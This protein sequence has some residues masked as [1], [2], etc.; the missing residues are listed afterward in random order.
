LAGYFSTFDKTASIVIEREKLIGVEYDYALIV[1][2]VMVIMVL[3]V[4]FPINVIPVKQI[5]V[6]KIFGKRH[7]LTVGQ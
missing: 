5:L 1:G 6:H 4:A 3:C 2:R 7:D